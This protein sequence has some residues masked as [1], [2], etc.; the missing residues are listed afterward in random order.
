MVYNN[1]LHV[2]R[3]ETLDVSC[4]VSLSLYQSACHLISSVE[5]LCVSH[6][7]P[8]LRTAYTATELGGTFNICNKNRLSSPSGKKCSIICFF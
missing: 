8:K 2:S 6:P 4:T 3:Y 7:G 1:C 5:Y